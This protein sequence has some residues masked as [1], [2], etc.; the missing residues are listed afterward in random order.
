MFTRIQLHFTSYTLSCA[1]HSQTSSSGFCHLNLKLTP[2]WHSNC[3]CGFEQHSSLCAF[4]HT[5]YPTP[6]G[7]SSSTAMAS[8]Q[9]EVYL[10]RSLQCHNIGERSRKEMAGLSD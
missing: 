6:T 8:S 7:I 5:I 4:D 3:L 1:S 10:T 2:Q 9:L